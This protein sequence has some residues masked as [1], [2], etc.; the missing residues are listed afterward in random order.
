MFAF[1]LENFWFLPELK[2]EWNHL[3]MFW[4]DGNSVAAKKGHK[5]IIWSGYVFDLYLLFLLIRNWSYY[6]KASV[7]LFTCWIDG[8]FWGILRPKLASYPIVL[9]GSST[10]KWEGNVITP[11]STVFPERKNSKNK[12]DF[13]RKKNYSTF[14]IA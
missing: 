13:L 1:E 6:F 14:W 9:S 5:N 2:V 7:F 4:F 11:P 12:L 10:L 3:C 8:G